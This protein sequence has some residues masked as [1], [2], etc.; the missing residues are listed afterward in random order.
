MKP[1]DTWQKQTS[2]WLDQV[3]IDKLGKKVGAEV[4]TIIDDGTMEGA[5]GSYKYDDEGV[6]AQKT[7]LIKNGEIVGLMHN[8]ETAQKY[9][10]KP[11]GNAQG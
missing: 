9:G 11:T 8:R 4:V 10:T 2:R 1:S 6:P 5:I 3:V 7:V